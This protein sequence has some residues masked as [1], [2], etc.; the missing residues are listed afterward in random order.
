VFAESGPANANATTAAHADRELRFLPMDGGLREIGATAAGFSFDNERPRHKVWVDPFA[1]SDRLVTVR[2]LA[3]FVREGGYRTPSLWLSEGYD[4]VRANGVD[5]PLHTSLLDGEVHVFTLTGT[6]VAAASDPVGHVSYYEADALARFWERACP[7]R[8]S[9][10]SRPRRAQATATATAPSSMTGSSA[11]PRRAR[12]RTAAAL[13]RR[14]GVDPERAISPTPV[15]CPPAALWAST[16]G[17][18]WST[19]RSCAEAR[20]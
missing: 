1:I 11:A 17:N 16:T 8:R 9:G 14:L 5:A 13:R 6:R 12:S 18:S 2:E 15:S 3:A 20:V 4:F 19:S 10:K 7:P